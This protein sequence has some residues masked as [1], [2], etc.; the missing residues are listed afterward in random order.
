M[1]YITITGRR[2]NSR[3]HIGEKCR[4]VR[5]IVASPFWKYAADNPKVEYDLYRGDWSFI[6]SLSDPDLRAFVEDLN[7]GGRTYE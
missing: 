4:T 5:E 2:I 1:F 7:R 6:G 3:R